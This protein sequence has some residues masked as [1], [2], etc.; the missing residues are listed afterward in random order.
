MF[1]DAITSLGKVLSRASV[2]HVRKTILLFKST[3]PFLL[4]MILPSLS[5]F[6]TKHGSERLG[7][8]SN[9][10]AKG[11]ISTK[12]PD[13]QTLCYRFSARF[14]DRLSPLPSGQ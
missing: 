14:Q 6:F 8:K 10:P 12:T 5:P 1:R 2:S 9:P 13:R 11:V 4:K 7:N 3:F